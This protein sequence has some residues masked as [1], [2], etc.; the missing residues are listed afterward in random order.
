MS[1]G[2]DSKPQI[3]GPNQNNEGLLVSILEEKATWILILPSTHVSICMDT[4]ASGLV[5]AH[6]PVSWAELWMRACPCGLLM[7]THILC[8]GTSDMYAQELM[9]VYICACT[10]ICIGVS[11]WVLVPVCARIG[12]HLRMNGQGGCTSCVCHS[13]H[14]PSADNTGE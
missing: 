1:K 9:H 7:S 13:G 10:H 8:T 4:W 11:V 6:M 14:G 12:L 3:F 2:K 5:C